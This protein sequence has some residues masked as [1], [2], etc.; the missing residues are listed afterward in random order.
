MEWITR[1]EARRLLNVSPNGLRYLEKRGL[2]FKV[3][4][5]SK[6]TNPEKLYSLDSIK[7]L[8]NR[9]RTHVTKAGKAI[10][11]KQGYIQVYH[12]QHPC[13][14]TNGYVYQH[15]LVMEEKLGRYLDK[16]EVVHHI[17]SDKSNNH[18]DNL[19]LIE[20]HSVHM[21]ESHELARKVLAL[22][23]NLTFRGR[24]IELIEEL[25]I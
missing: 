11:D 18:P 12:P 13:S 7:T 23:S 4:E 21:S 16:L 19:E 25:N 8:Q 22:C 1:Q 14:N 9:K 3:L 10:K 5:D 15:R 6:Y 17:D 2:A 24:L 20:S